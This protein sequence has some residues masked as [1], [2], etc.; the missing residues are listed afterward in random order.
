MPGNV[1]ETLAGWD[2]VLCLDHDNAGLAATKKL[3]AALSGK[4]RSLKRWRMSR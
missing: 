3:E 4:V 1:A 2:I